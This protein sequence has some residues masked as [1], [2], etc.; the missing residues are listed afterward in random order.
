MLC[1]ANGAVAADVIFLQDFPGRLPWIQ[2]SELQW[3][4]SLVQGMGESSI[5]SINI[6]IKMY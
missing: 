3:I 6:S 5:I 1:S 2:W 4:F